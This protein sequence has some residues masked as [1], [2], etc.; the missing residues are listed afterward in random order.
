MVFAP[1]RGRTNAGTAPQR[2]SHAIRLTLL[3]I[4]VAGC[5][6]APLEAA[7]VSAS[8]LAQG[9]MA[10]WSFDELS[11]MTVTDSSGNLPAR[12]G[13]TSGNPRWG[14]E[15]RF[16]TALRM[17]A[18]DSVV[19]SGFAPPITPAL[20]VSGWIK[21]SAEDRMMLSNRAVL[22]TSEQ[23]GPGGA[24]GWEIEFA[25]NDGFDYLEAS[26]WA[27]PP[28]N[29][30]VILRC[31]CI[32]LDVW[33]HWT[34]VFDSTDSTQKRFRLYRDGV[35]VD[36]AKLPVQPLPGT[37]DLF[38]GKWHLGPRPIPGVIDDYAIWS[39]ALTAEEIFTVYTRGVPHLP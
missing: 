15:G 7:G 12:E 31:K 14:V 19:F 32:D 23:G 11:G 16:G 36:T 13:I 25:P 6:P 18:S 24:G 10:H 4:C 27:G 39:R 8:T 26:Y 1:L 38:I 33:M 30:F 3:F 22:L 37:P 34:V 35:S 17:Q 2:Q 28:I 29:E 20:T 9:L 5:G 21:L